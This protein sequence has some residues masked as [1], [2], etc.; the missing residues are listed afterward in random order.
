MARTTQRRL[1]ELMNELFEAA[2]GKREGIEALAAC[3]VALNEKVTL[4]PY[5]DGEWAASGFEGSGGEC[6]WVE[7]LISVQEIVDGSVVAR[8]KAML[9]PEH[10]ANGIPH[11]TLGALEV[12]WQ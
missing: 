3:R 2:G 4:S 8:I 6:R 12:A 11:E 1:K 10:D 9:P 7:R 5:K